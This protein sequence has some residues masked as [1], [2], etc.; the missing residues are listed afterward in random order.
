MILKNV[1]LV[2][3]ENGQVERTENIFIE[4]GIIKG[5]N[6]DGLVEKSEAIDINFKYVLPG[7][8]DL[9]VHVAEEP[10]TEQAKTFNFDE[11]EENSIKRLQRNLR[12]ALFAGVTGLRD[13]GSFS[14]RGLLAKKLVQNGK[15]IGPRIFTCGHA[16]TPL[17]GHWFERSREVADNP[18][19][20]KTAVEEE[21]KNGADFIKIMIEIPVFFSQVTIK[22]A[23]D[24][25]HNFNK[26]IAAHAAYLKSIRLAIEAGVDSL[27]HTGAIPSLLLKKAIKQK[28]VIVPTFYG[29]R[30]SVEEPEKALL[31]D[32]DSSIPGNEQEVYRLFVKWLEILKG[33]LP[34]LFKSGISIGAGTDAGFPMV[35][36]Y[37]VIS[38]VQALNS[39]GLEKA[40]CL[41]AATIIAA[42]L[43][44]NDSLIGSIRVGKLADLIVVDENPLEN[45]KTLENTLLVMKEGAVIKNNLSF[46]SKIN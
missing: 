39:L 23:V 2:N 21:I 6:I 46:G 31:Y 28:T 18:E 30:V 38:E 34:K 10:E 41:Q 33:G 17:K 4:D 40:R 9:H 22:A 35:P 3:V 43:L 7:L 15:I 20:M 13:V 27:E 26:K 19:L 36:F 8:I 44:D 24:T 42:K 45:L 16:L 5:I 25:A 14:G 12:R 29:A 1:N 32:T 37:S 11:P